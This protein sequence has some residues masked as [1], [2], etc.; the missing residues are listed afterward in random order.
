MFPVLISVKNVIKL[1]LKY[2]QRVKVDILKTQIMI[3]RNVLRI[4][5]LALRELFVKHAIRQQH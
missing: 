4:A 1:P 2:V 5:L 3:A